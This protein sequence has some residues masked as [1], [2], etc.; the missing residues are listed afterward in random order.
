[1][2]DFKVL[3]HFAKKAEILGHI[4]RNYRQ[5]KSVYR[6][7]NL[8]AYSQVLNER[9]ALI[10]ALKRLNSAH[11]T[12]CSSPFLKLQVQLLE[13]LLLEIQNERKSQ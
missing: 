5:Q 8:S 2:N 7:K 13:Q 3:S 10:A 1:M 12:E 11:I 9:S 4:L 6:D